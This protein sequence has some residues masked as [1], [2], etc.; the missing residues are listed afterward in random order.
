MSNSS[1][2]GKNRIFDNVKLSKSSPDRRFTYIGSDQPRTIVA[3]DQSEDLLLR[4][5]DRHD[6]TT[7]NHD[8]NKEIIQRTEN[9]IYEVNFYRNSES[10]R[11]DST[12][13]MLY[14][15]N[16]ASTLLIEFSDKI[17]L[18]RFTKLIDGFKTSSQKSIFSQRTDS[19]SASQYFQF[20]GYLSQQ[21]NMMQDYVRTSTYQRAILANSDDFKDKV[22]LDVGAGS[23][24]LSFFALQ[25][26][27]KKVYAVEASS[28]AKHAQL[29]VQANS[30]VGK[31]EVLAGKIEEINLPEPVDIIISEPMGYMLFNERMLETY[32]HAKKWFK[33][34]EQGRM[35]PSRGDLHVAPFTDAQL[36]MEQTNKANFWL[37]NDFHGVNLCALH[38]AATNEY[39]R[40]PIVDTF[41]IRICMAKTIRHT[42]DFQKA[43]ETDL[44]CINIPLEFISNQ[45]GQIHGLAFWFDVAFIGTQQTIWLSTAPS[46]QLT[47]WYQVRCLLNTP[48]FVNRG[49]SIIGHCVLRSNK[50]QS[51]D[52]DIELKIKEL[53]TRASNSLDLKNP[54]FRYTGQPVQP[55]P[56]MNEISPS[57]QYWSTYET[58][59]MTVNSYNGTTMPI[60]QQSQQISVSGVGDHLNS[61]IINRVNPTHINGT[62]I[63]PMLVN[64]VTNNVQSNSTELLMPQQQNQNQQQQQH[65]QNQQ[66]Q[67]Q[68]LQHQQQGLFIQQHI[69]PTFPQQ[70][71]YQQQLVSEQQPVTVAYGANYQQQS[72]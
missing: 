65:Q 36:Y 48:L 6:N 52:V 56:G 32:L 34:P 62:N 23:G 44:H 15:E 58:V 7:N 31:I 12:S 68:Q 51:Y 42:V 20:Y 55:P 24:I 16:R 59:P 70:Q 47:H 21:Q 26:G 5:T 29:L 25:A 10:S 71:L 9:V 11:F 2:V 43:H 30:C 19:A 64:G 4:F 13:Y 49:Q 8:N 53:G 38:A 28:M 14:E 46:Q 40:Q 22:V 72:S 61:N 41:D 66:L 67:H 3:I 69:A 63:I 57:E 18:D 17:E 60:Q 39:F 45:T 1:L 33:S 35:F 27:A 37:S 54:Y 50:R